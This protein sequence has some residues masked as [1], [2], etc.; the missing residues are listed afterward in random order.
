MTP[1]RA[2]ELA[3]L[4]SVTYASLFDYPLTLAQ[5]H[6]SLVEMHAD[7]PSVAS[8]WRDSAFLQAT[9]EHRDGLYFPSRRADLL[10]TRARREALSRDLLERE[11]RVLSLVARTP[12]VRMVALSGSL[13][14]LNAERSADLDL[15]VITA[16]GRVWSVTLSVLVISRLLGWR[17]RMCLNYVISERAMTIE[18]A[19]LF[20]ANQIIHLRPVVGH[21]VFEQFV[22]ANP[23]VKAVLSEFRRERGTGTTQDTGP[24]TQDPCRARV[25]PG[26]RRATGVDGASDLRLASQT[27]G[28]HLA[29]DR[30]G[31]ARSG[32]P[33]TAHQQPSRRDA[34]TLRGRRGPGAP[35]RAERNTR[36]LSEER[37]AGFPRGADNFVLIPRDTL[38]LTG[39]LHPAISGKI[40]VKSGFSGWMARHE[41]CSIGVAGSIRNGVQQ[42]GLC[43]IVGG[44]P[45]GGSRWVLSG[46]EAESILRL[47]SARHQRAPA[48]RRRNRGGPE[49][50]S[51]GHRI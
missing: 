51:H 32:V 39:Q 48:R 40:G 50:T 33:E 28:R 17:K 1:T 13:A 18:P 3:F 2:Q 6:A 24:K 46:G 45:R 49:S 27:A 25:G 26:P 42:A 34:R 21:E 14:H 35:G 43:G 44:V 5:L 15:F 22:N 20:S 23:F 47:R 12:F 41:P 37:T 31:A 7:A 11:H 10:P 4:R 29:V 30:P 8:W 36:V 9:V 19:D 16:P 38:H